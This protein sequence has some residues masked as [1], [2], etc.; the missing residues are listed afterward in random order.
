MNQSI[1]PG[2]SAPLR[3][4]P[5]MASRWL[6]TDLD[7]DTAAEQLVQTHKADGE[8]TD[9]PVMDLRT[10]GIR[11]ERGFFSLA[12]LTGHQPPRPLR[13]TAYSNLSTRLGAPSDFIKKLPAELQLANLNFLL[14][15]QPRPLSSQ[16]R[17]RGD[18]VSAVVSERYAALD[19]EE[20][21]D[22]VRLALK[23]EGVLDDVRVRAIATGTTDAL[24]LV[25]PGEETELQVGDVSHVGLDISTSS[26]GKS[27]VHVSGMVW[28]LVCLNGLR[29]PESMGRMSFRHVGETARLQAGL[30]D[31]VP[32]ALFHARGLMGHWQKAVAAEVNHV[33]DLIDG[34][35]ELTLGERENVERALNQEH[36]T[37][38]LPGKVSLYSFINGITQA[39]HQAVPAR[40]LEMESVAGRILAQ[41]VA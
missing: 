26:F 24:R 34:M 40:R 37:A 19:A 17:L 29:S 30:R 7:F 38:E 33:K 15:S 1:H 8:V 10:W 3:V 12:P 36:G 9:Q 31:A 25:L 14:A 2:L 13:Q 27:A 5:D 16:L 6:A 21:V 39:A 23:T 35:R 28:R 4:L 41:E 18:N 20:F 32:T 11:G 22:S